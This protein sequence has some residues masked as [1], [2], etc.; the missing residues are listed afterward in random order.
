MAQNPHASPNFPARFFWL[1]LPSLL[2]F[3]LLPLLIR[4]G[5][6]FWS[7]FAVSVAATAGCYLTMLPVLRKFG[8]Q[9]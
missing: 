7:S 1:V 8:V 5:F 4:Y 9:L 6:G 3:L 2:L